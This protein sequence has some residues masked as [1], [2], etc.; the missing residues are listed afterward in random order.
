[1]EQFILPVLVVA[2]VQSHLSSAQIPSIALS[3]GAVP[4]LKMPVTGLGTGGYI[5]EETGIPGEIWNDS[6]AEQATM[7]WLSLGGRHIDAALKY[8][9]QVGVGRGVKVSGIPRKDIFITSKLLLAGYNETFTQMD[10]ILK[11]LQLDYVD[12]LLVHYPK[13]QPTSTDPSCQQDLPSWRGCRQSVW[14][15]M[16]EIF[17][18]KQARAIGISNF[19]QQHIEDLIIMNTTLPAVN[20]VEFQPYWHEKSLVDYCQAKGIAFDS[21]SSLGTPDWAPH[22][23]NWNGTIL[24]LPV[25]QNIAKVHGCSAAQVLQKWA[26]QQGIVMNVRTSNPDHMKENLN[27]FDFNLSDSEMEQISSIK[28][29]ANPKVCPDFRNVK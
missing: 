24:A 11:E 28:P 10:Q 19:E 16:G 17:S 2:L 15:A 20:Q 29:P 22:Q 4:G 25:I 6:V 7:E 23:R 1:M 12:L 9:D 5:H 14:K 18:K 8:L 27:F 13:P 3:N 26:W 21:Y